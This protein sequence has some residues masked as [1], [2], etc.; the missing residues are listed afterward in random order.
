[1]LLLIV[2]LTRDALGAAD[3]AVARGHRVVVIVGAADAW[4]YD[5]PT[6]HAEDLALARRL[7]EVVDLSALGGGLPKLQALLRGPGVALREASWAGPPVGRGRAWA[8]LRLLPVLAGA[9]WLRW[10]LGRRS[11][12]LRLGEGGAFVAPM[13]AGAAPPVW[14]SRWPFDGARLAGPKA[15]RLLLA[16]NLKQDYLLIKPLLAQLPRDRV[17]VVISPWL[18][19]KL[20][21]ALDQMATLGLA[22]TV[23]A[24]APAQRTQYLQACGG[25]IARLLAVTETRQPDHQ[26]SRRWVE[27]CNRLGIETVTLQHGFENIGLTYFD[28]RSPP[29]PEEFASQVVLTWCAP[30][31]LAP[32]VPAETRR[33]CQPIGYPKAAA[34]PRPDI[35]RR[36][37]PARLLVGVFENLHW[38]RYTD[39]YREAFVQGLALAAAA[40][41]AWVFVVKTHPAGQWLRRH[42]TAAA[43]MA[44]ASNIVL[45]NPQDDFWS[46]VAA[47]ELLPHISAVI[48]TPSTVVLDAAVHQVP[49]GVVAGDMALPNY[50]PLP[51]LRQP[52]DWVQFLGE[53]RDGA[54]GLQGRQ[55]R[56]AFVERSVCG[57]DGLLRLIQRCAVR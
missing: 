30:G 44:E 57:E 5:S 33:K 23:V 12:F 55:R 48:S 14:Q 56:E 26:W 7:A 8:L 16:L 47:E 28:L 38:H 42:N 51:L 41:P 13:P 54:L 25:R 53:L 3:L 32:E 40:H 21:A 49:V 39:S 15:P 20:P 1:M 52:A 31:A 9:G 34:Q 4:A 37:P 19:A 22:V 2:G 45:L 46:G 43:A 10:L 35:V 36:L 17:A 11:L 29:H 18:A 50:E 6:A 24:D 27:E